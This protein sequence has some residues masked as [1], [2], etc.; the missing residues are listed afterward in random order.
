MSEKNIILIGFMG[1]GKSTVAVELVRYGHF[2][3]LDLDAEI[4]RMAGISIQEI[5]RQRGESAFRELESQ[6]LQELVGQK[7]LVV[8]T[9]GGILGL[10][11]NRDLIKSIG[12]TVY[13]RATFPALQKRLSRSIHRPLVKEQPDWMA[14]ESL[15]L[16]RIPLYET[17]DLIIDTDN[18]TPK[19]IATE[20]L[21][22]LAEG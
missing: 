6:S 12:R 18:K 2:C 19:E 20:I 17:A 13:L 5:F 3:L 15:L 4:E 14:L 22:K 1:A 8:A 7:R 11:Q 21:H 9:G 10:S 16:S